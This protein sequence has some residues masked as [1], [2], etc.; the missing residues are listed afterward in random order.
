MRKEIYR[1]LLVSF[2]F[3]SL[4]IYGKEPQILIAYS[5][6][7][8][9][10]N[11]AYAQVITGIEKKLNNAKKLEIDAGVDVLQA[12]LNHNS[13]DKIIALG[14]GVVDA[15]YKTSYR[16]QTLAGLMF[17]KSGDYSGVSL[18]LDSRVLVDQLFHLVPTVKRVFI[19][20]QAHNQTI[21]Y[22]PA[23]DES[24]PALEVRE[25]VDSLSTIRL[26]GQLLEKEASATDAV[27]IPANLPNNILYEVAKIAW[28]KKVILLSTNL[29]HLENGALMVAYPDGVAL[30]EQLG[31]LTTRNEQPSYES[32]TGVSLALN[33]RVAQHLTIEFDQ[34]SLDL[35]ALK[36]K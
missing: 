10:Q 20:Q 31:R 5:G 33:R 22:F 11:S 34:A 23:I 7:E 13:P 19:I 18:A 27:F 8:A 9:S 29:S 15:V 2:I 14:K 35:F 21:D 17:F 24:S 32:V 28:D 36:I 6:I 25:G 4:P 12:L 26:L 1:I 30:G 16:E 3:F